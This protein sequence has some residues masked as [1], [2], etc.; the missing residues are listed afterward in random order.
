MDRPGD[1]GGPPFAGR[2]FRANAVAGGLD[3]DGAPV[4]PPPELTHARL[5]DGLLRDYP[6]YTLRALL[7]ED[8]FDLLQ[9]RSIL[10]PECG[11]AR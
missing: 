9:M 8:A 1:G 5:L 2:V 7:D 11:K 3:A 10:D 6:G 4:V